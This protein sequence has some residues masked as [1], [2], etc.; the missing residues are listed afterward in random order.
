M[1]CL[2]QVFYADM[3]LWGKLT[4]STEPAGAQGDVVCMCDRYVTWSQH[5]LQIKKNIRDKNKITTLKTYIL[6]GRLKR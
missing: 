5:T 2:P 4:A 1:V 6:R 3:V